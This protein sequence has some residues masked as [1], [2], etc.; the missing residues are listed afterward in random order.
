MDTPRSVLVV[1]LG[2]SGQAACRLLL[3]QGARVLAVDDGAAAG[4]PGVERVNVAG[5]IDAL[6]AVELVVVSPGV[7]ASHRVLA[8]ARELRVEIVSELE[9]GFHCVSAPVA[10]ITGTNGKSTT[11][12]LLARMLEAD[13][14]RV[15]LGGNIG[16][17]LCNVAGGVFDVCVVEVSTFQLEWTRRFRPAVAAVLNLSPDHLDRHG[18]M[19]AYKALKLRL[20]ENMEEDDRAVFCRDQ[21]WWQT[22]VGRLRPR[23]STFGATPCEGEGTIYDAGRRSVEATGGWRIEAA[24]AWPRAV[25]DFENLAAACEMARLL[26]VDPEAAERAVRTFGGLPHRLVLVGRRAGIEFWNDS[27][28]TNPGAALR[29]VEAMA[30]PVI[31]LAGGESK[32]TDFSVLAAAATRLRLVV[33]YGAAADRIDTALSGVVETKRAGG[34]A[35]AFSRAV[36]SA[37]RGDCVL[38]APACASFDEFRD[39]AERGRRFEELVREWQW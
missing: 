2:S 18:S 29:S 1:G 8:R 37:R 30:G 6:R 38:L 34:L 35:E 39:Y 26:G 21:Q 27:K 11:A 13:G 31:L 23:L 22:S 25:H 17:P 24:G 12:T 5:A 7:P 15:F 20:L 36:G 3:E 10:A 4:P 9:L 14:R 19:A 33:A 28:A 16:N 32:G